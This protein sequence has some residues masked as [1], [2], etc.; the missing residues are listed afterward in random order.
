M[1]IC[2]YPPW[3]ELKIAPQ[4]LFFAGVQI[5]P[6]YSTSHL[7]TRKALEFIHSGRLHMKNLITHRFKLAQTEQAF[8]TALESKEC[9]KVVVLRDDQV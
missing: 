8:K 6:S 7:E 4:D 5:I 3:K 2:T 1:R 9:L